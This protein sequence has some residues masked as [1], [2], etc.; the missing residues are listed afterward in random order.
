ML[1]RP[2][3]STRTDTLCPYTTLFRSAYN[4]TNCVLHVF[5]Y[6]KVGGTDFRVLTYEVKGGPE[7]AAAGAG[8]GAGDPAKA[9]EAK[10]FAR[11]CLNELVAQAKAGRAGETTPPAGPATPAAPAGGGR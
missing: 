4:G 6:P 8:A 1:R 2:P 9:A 11:L 3:R 5:F 10:D 7:V